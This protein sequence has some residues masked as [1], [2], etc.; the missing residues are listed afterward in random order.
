MIK[1]KQE[2]PIIVELSIDNPQKALYYLHKELDKRMDVRW[3]VV[4]GKS[5]KI[6]DMTNQQ[7]QST[8][9]MLEKMIMNNE[10]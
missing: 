4:D 8:I 2:K 1:R 7:I 10:G 6:E 5:I 3:H 9:N